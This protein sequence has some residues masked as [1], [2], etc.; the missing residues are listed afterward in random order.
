M[1]SKLKIFKIK[2][3]K[4]CV[5][6]EEDVEV[7]PRVRRRSSRSDD[8]A[9][10]SLEEEKINSSTCNKSKTDIKSD[11]LKSRAAK[12]EEVSQRLS[13]DYNKNNKMSKTNYASPTNLQTKKV[14]ECRN[15]FE[16]DDDFIRAKQDDEN[17]KVERRRHT[18]ESRERESTAE[19]MKRIS[20]DTKTSPRYVPIYL[21]L[22]TEMPII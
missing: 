11:S 13:T 17:L 20:L 1:L 12:F 15:N 5:L 22:L 16:K 14:Q 21:N 8:S 19:R 7:L 6:E 18:Y 3:E 9:I 4:S 2:D 10:D